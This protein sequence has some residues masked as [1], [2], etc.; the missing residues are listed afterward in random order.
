MINDVPRDNWRGM[1]KQGRYR[2]LRNLPVGFVLQILH[3]TDRTERWLRILTELVLLS[4]VAKCLLAVSLVHDWV[5][6]LLISSILVHFVSWLFIGNFWVYMLGS[7]LWVRNPGITKV[8]DYVSFCEGVFAATDACDAILIYGS[9]SRSMFHGRSDLDL[10]VVRRRGVWHALKAIYAGMY[11]RVVSFFR[12]IPVD[13]QVVDSME[14]L[15]NSMREDEL[16]IVVYSRYS[17]I[18]PNPG[19]SYRDVLREPATV[20]RRD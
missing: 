6:A 13:L 9:M 2:A 8:L 12:G 14:F 1:M 20:L 17:G 16:P 19:Y 4:V 18:V 3:S 10:R 11:V 7:F 5:G 15:T